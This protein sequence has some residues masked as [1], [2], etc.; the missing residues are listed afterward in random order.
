[1]A[2]SQ[3]SVAQMAGK[4]LSAIF[5]LDLEEYFIIFLLL[6]LSHHQDINSSISPGNEGYIPHDITIPA[7]AALILQFFVA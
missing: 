6:L 3:N 2:E 7:L 1:M 5:F 4:L